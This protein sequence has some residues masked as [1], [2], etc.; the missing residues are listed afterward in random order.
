MDR[1]PLEKGSQ[2]VV[3][4]IQAR[5][6]EHERQ[7]PRVFLAQGLAAIGALNMGLFLT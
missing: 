7:L 5:C 3:Q 2:V 1:D 6:Q 4:K